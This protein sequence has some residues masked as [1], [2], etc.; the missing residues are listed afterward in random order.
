VDREGY[1]YVVGETDSS[2]FPST[3]QALK[4]KS[5]VS[6]NDWIGFAA[7]LSPNANR[8]IYSTF[9]GGSYRTTATAVDVDRAGN[10]FVV[11]TTC[12]SNFPV[13]SMA[14]QKH[15]PGG[16]QGLEGCDAFVAKLDPSGSRYLYS[17]YLGGSAA[18]TATSILIDSNGNAWVAG[19]TS[20]TDFPVTRDAIAPHLKGKRNGFLAEIDPEGKH[21]LYGTYIGGAGD[22][23]IQAITGRGDGIIYLVGASDSADFLRCARREDYEG[24]VLPFSIEHRA[25]AGPVLSIGGGGYT[26]AT[27]ATTR[28]DG[29]VYIAGTTASED[30]PTTANAFQSRLIGNNDAFWVRLR[31]DEKSGSL[32]ILYASLLGGSRETSGDA[33]TVDRDDAVLLAGRTT[34]TD[35]PITPTALIRQ[36]RRTEDAYLTKFSASGRRVEFGS[37]VGGGTRPTTWNE[38]VKGLATD[39]QGN[40]YVAATVNEPALAGTRCALAPHPA[41]NTEVLLLKLAFLDSHPANGRF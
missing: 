41:G 25:P 40:I 23:S 10:A 2:D 35:F 18:D 37:F 20:S 13:T 24:F 12:S 7:K 36:L 9:I 8:V 28:A 34:S 26:A 4:K 31:R 19:F 16:G 15:A 30:F 22:D 29:D 27:A 33:I 3:P 39:E 5:G 11:G 6:N 38:G 32:R 17:T 14:F 21:L 1:I